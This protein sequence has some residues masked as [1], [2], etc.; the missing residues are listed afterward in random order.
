[1]AMYKFLQDM[2]SYIKERINADADISKTYGIEM[3]D[4]YTKGHTPTKTEVQFQ[5]IDKNEVDRY[6]SFEGANVFYVPLQIT[7]VAF[8]MK[9]AGVMTSPREGSLLLGDKIQNILNAKQDV[10]RAIPRITKVRLMTTSPSLPYEGGD[11][12]YT[13]AIRCEFWIAKE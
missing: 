7:V 1:M 9:I 4:A 6:S 5:I 8:Q 11:K 2:K 10:V 3:Y 13:T 12:A